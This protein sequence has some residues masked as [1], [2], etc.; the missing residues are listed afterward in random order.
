MRRGVAFRCRPQ[1]RG[2][3]MSTTYESL[4]GETETDLY[5]EMEALIKK[6]PR[7]WKSVFAVLGLAGGVMAPALGATADMITWF[8]RS[9]SINSYLHVA[10]I[11]LC[12][13]T[14]PLLMLGAH[15]LDSLES[16]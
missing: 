2:G 11:V 14:I 10:S 9:Q 8:V 7:A 13:L 16:K 6:N 15:C 4:E 12:T 5:Q 1:K 3:E